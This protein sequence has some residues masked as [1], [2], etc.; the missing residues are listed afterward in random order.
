MKTSIGPSSRAIVGIASKI[1][2]SLRFRKEPTVCLDQDRRVAVQLGVVQV[3]LQPTSRDLDF[4]PVAAGDDAVAL[5]FGE[6]RSQVGAPEVGDDD[7]EVAAAQALEEGRIEVILVLV[8]HVQESFLPRIGEPVLYVGSEVM[9]PRI[10]EPRRI[11]GTARREPG[12]GDDDRPRR[13][14]AEAGVTQECDSHRGEG[15]RAWSSSRGQGPGTLGRDRQRG[16]PPSPAS[17]PS[18]R[19]VSGRRSSPRC[20]RGAGADPRA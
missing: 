8:A 13:L 20:V 15:G 11:E 6:R 16:T 2:Q 1:R 7:G 9:V 3:E 18:A 5:I 19:P 10:L 4:L 17:R 12:V 14:D